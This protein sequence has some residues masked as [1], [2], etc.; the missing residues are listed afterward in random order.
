MDYE[1]LRI[2]NIKDGN[3]IGTVETRANII[4]TLIN[5]GYV[6][7]DKTTYKI[8]DKGKELIEAAIQFHI[9]I[10]KEKAIQL[11]AKSCIAFLTYL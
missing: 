9:D 6:I 4:K 7:L 8:T 3:E 1:Q 11:F 5:W 10:G 2:K